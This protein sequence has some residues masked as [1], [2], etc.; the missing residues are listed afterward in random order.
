[1]KSNGKKNLKH[2]ELNFE[3]IHSSHPNKENKNVIV[4]LIKLPF[5]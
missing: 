2:N 5:L 1:M 3:Q 4:G